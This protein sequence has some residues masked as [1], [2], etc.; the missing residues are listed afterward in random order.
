MIAILG[1][2]GFIRSSLVEALISREKEPLVIDIVKSKGDYNWRA[3]YP[4]PRCLEVVD[5]FAKKRDSE[6]GVKFA[7]AF[8]LTKEFVE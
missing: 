4:H 3:P 8:V 2:S 6:V 7:E 5:A 1:A